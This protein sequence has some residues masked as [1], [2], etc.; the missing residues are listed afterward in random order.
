MQSLL[1][2]TES[3]NAYYRTGKLH[4][5]LKRYTAIQKVIQ[6]INSWLLSSYNFFSQAFNEF[7]DDQYDFHGYN[8]RKFTVN[9]YL[10]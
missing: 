8:L 7:E 5:A 10:T 3:A 1:Y 4:L 6:S 2:L 9:V